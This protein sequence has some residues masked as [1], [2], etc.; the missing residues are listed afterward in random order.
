MKVKT[1]FLQGNALRYAVAR[2]N[3]EKPQCRA[4]QAYFPNF[5]YYTPDLDWGLTGPIM[6][7][8]R[9]T[10]GWNPL[11]EEWACPDPNNAAMSILGPT[12]KV[13][14]LRCYVATKLGPEVDIPEE[15]LK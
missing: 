8:N 6:E 15:F 4:G 11:W 5:G 3:G 12:P 7:E 13:A 1:A 2:A 14:I 9:I 10:V